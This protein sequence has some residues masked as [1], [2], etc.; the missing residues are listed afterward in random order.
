M[1]LTFIHCKCNFKK[2]KQYFLSENY[3]QT[4]PNKKHKQYK[5]HEKHKKIFPCEN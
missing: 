4:P 5:A 2:R 3:E 1:Y